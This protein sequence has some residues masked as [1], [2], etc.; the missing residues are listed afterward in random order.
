MREIEPYEMTQP[1]AKAGSL[2]N[3]GASAKTSF[4]APIFN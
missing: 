3:I 1:V 2:V 4:C